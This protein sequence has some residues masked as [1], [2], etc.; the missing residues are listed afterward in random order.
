MIAIRVSA[1]FA[2]KPYISCLYLIMLYFC[3]LF[4]RKNKY[5]GI[6]FINL[7]HFFIFCLI[8][9]ATNCILEIEITAFHFAPRK[10]KL[11]ILLPLKLKL[12]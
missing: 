6:I 12:I 3:I 7:S 2:C 1:A 4:V 5:Y 11:S 9:T 10:P 8:F